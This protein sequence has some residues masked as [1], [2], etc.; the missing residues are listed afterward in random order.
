MNWGTVLSLVIC[1]AIL[2]LR[3]MLM[4]GNRQ[5]STPR[6]RI[7]L[8]RIL[9]GGLLA[10]AAIGYML[11]RDVHNLDGKTEYEPSLMERVVMK[12]NRR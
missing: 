11:K 6:Q 3:F 7:K 5:R 1:L 12:L 2:T 10:L 4:P 9:I 8:A